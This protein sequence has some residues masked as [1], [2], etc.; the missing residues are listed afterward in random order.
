MIYQITLN[1]D[2]MNLHPNA[3]VNLQLVLNKYFTFRPEMAG[4]PVDF[5]EAENKEKHL[6]APGLKNFN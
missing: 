1:S 5:G 6:I 2:K 3:E 4:V